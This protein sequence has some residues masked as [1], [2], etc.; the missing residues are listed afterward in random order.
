MLAPWVKWLIKNNLK[1][2]AV[3]IW[4]IILPLYWL[5]YIKVAMEDAIY[6]LEQIKTTEKGHL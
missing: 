6:D 3:I 2:I 1:F 4:F 5:S